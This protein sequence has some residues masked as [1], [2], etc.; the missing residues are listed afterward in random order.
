MVSLVNFFGF[1]IQMVLCPV[2]MLPWLFIRL[3]I[4]K[5]PNVE[6]GNMDFP[7]SAFATDVSNYQ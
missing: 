6:E 1:L 3:L 4:S 7:D 5:A 2:L